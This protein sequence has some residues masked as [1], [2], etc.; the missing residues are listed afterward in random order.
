MLIRVLVRDRSFRSAQLL[1]EATIKRP[2]RSSTGGS[3]D[4]LVWSAWETALFL[5]GSVPSLS[6]RELGVYP[7]WS[8]CPGLRLTG[9]REWYGLNRLGQQDPVP[10]SPKL[11]KAFF[12]DVDTNYTPVA[13][14]DPAGE[15]I[16]GLYDRCARVLCSII[17]SM[18]TDPSQPT[19]LLL[20]SH[21]ATFVMLCRALSGG[22]PSDVTEA[23]YIPWTAGLTVFRRRDDK[24]SGV[25]G[26]SPSEHAQHA[27]LSS[28]E[29]E[30]RGDCSFLS[31]GPERGWYVWTLF[32]V[33]T[34]YLPPKALL[35]KRKF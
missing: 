7:F 4:V 19:T 20:R 9:H 29:C 14:P 2:G 30:V 25:P 3:S 18:D 27:T 15:S 1:I 33:M 28:L 12:P 10:S 13:E 21:A 31:N 8:T 6:S 16:Q 17:S 34:T 26:S 24:S 11:L 35:R 5:S 22:I 23:D 32:L